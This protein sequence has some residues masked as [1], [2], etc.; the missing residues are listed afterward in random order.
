MSTSDTRHELVA[1]LDQRKQALDRTQERVEEYGEDDLQELAD[2]YKPFFDVL[3]VYQDQVTGDDGDIQTIVEF[4]G[5]VDRVMGEVPDDVIHADIFEECDEYLRQKWFSDS[6]FEHVYGLLDPIEALVERLHE[7]DDALE[8][9]REARRDV[10]TRLQECEDEIDELE[11]LSDLS[12]ADLDAPIERLEDPISE[13]NDAVE[14]AFRE[15]KRSGSAR[16]VVRFLDAMEQYPLVEF[17]SPPPVVVEYIEE[18][19]P[20]EE[21]IATILDY[22][23]YSHSKL[24]HYVDE[25]NKLKHAIE[26]H[27]A[28][29]EALDGGPLTVSWPPPTAEQLRYRCQE[30]TAAVN[31]ID[32]A[33]VELLRTVQALP[34]NTEYER[35]RRSAV[36]MQ[37]LSAE[38]R[39]QLQSRPIDDDLA[40]LRAERDRL[41]DALESYPDR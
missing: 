1:T 7:R 35:L 6:D 5:E 31:R 2:A 3:D 34:R 20:G 19:P 12:E 18:N 24:E 36:V 29:L 10:Q 28:Y 41:Q 40:E 13:Y 4:Q 14:D 38:E 17:Q 21:P 11:R 9:Y 39:E 22:A 27:R 15:F 37:E 33:V 30:L 8:A 26:G 23:D 32:P 25:P 16:D